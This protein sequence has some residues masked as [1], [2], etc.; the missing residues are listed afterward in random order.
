M[1]TT[2]QEHQ[3]R[4]ERAIADALEALRD[5]AKHTD[6]GDFTQAL[7]YIVH[8]AMRATGIAEQE[9][10]QARDAAILESNRDDA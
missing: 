10:R 4:A 6:R 7:N 2:S 9:L 8:G 1:S 3:Q 5:A